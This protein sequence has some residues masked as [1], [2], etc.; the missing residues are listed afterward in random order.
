[1]TCFSQP[2]LIAQL[3]SAVTMQPL[4]QMS[5]LQVCFQGTLQLGMILCDRTLPMMG[6]THMGVIVT[7]E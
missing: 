3:V 1:V 2:D 7:E 5:M 6:I 4:L